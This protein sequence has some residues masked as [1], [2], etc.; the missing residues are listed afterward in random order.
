MNKELQNQ[1]LMTETLDQIIKQFENEYHLGGYW[2]HKHLCTFEMICPKDKEKKCAEW[3]AKHPIHFPK[4][5][6]KP[7]C[8]EDYCD[9]CEMM[10]YVALDDEGR[11]IYVS[12]SFPEKLRKW[13]DLRT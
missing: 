13:F 10:N 8:T 9:F 3:R 7:T 5:W 1:V 11:I 12:R 2:N 6:H 4:K